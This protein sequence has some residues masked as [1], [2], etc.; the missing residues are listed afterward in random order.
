MTLGVDKYTAI[1]YMTNSMALYNKAILANDM[2]EANRAKQIC[3]N[4]IAV[5]E[6]HGDEYKPAVRFREHRRS[7]DNT[8]VNLYDHV[9]INGQRYTIGS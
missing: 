9:F 6:S 4:M 5:V 1:V 8:T 3:T 2:A 7:I